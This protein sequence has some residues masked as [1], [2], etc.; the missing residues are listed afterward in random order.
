MDF[1]FQLFILLHHSG[2]DFHLIWGFNILQSS[3]CLTEAIL[4]KK[5]RWNLMGNGGVDP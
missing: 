1:R 3:S 2:V 4:G 5:E